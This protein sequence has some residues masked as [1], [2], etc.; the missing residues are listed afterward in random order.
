MTITA[1]PIDTLIHA[2]FGP[3]IITVEETAV[4]TI[5]VPAALEVSVIVNGIARETLYY[6]AI[7]TEISA[8][9]L[10]CRFKIDLS[11]VAQKWLHDSQMTFIN[12][13]NTSQLV[14]QSPYALSIA[15]SITSYLPNTEG[16]LVKNNAST[17]LSTPFK[18]SGFYLNETESNTII[19]PF[20]AT[21]PQKF[22]TNIPSVVFVTPTDKVF[23]YCFNRV[24]TALD[25]VVNFYNQFNALIGTGSF[26]FQPL[27]NGVSIVAFGPSSVQ[28]ANWETTN[29][30]VNVNDCL[31]YDVSIVGDTW[32]SEIKRF[33]IDFA[34]N[35]YRLHFLNKMG[36]YDFVF[37]NTDTKES[38]SVKSELFERLGVGIST[39]RQS[40]LGSAG[41]KSHDGIA[42]NLSD[43]DVIWLEELLLSPSVFWENDGQIVPIIVEDVTNVLKETAEQNQLKVSFYLSKKRYSQKL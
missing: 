18:T 20:T 6:D 40:R 13:Y 30:N 34:C 8:T 32:T 38:M 19:N 39:H 42:K 4:G 23:L 27:Q 1:Q 35:G 5:S 41:Q 14:S 22:L 29:G 7:E 31:Y 21:I 9:D 12:N 24:P 2:A 10:V 15:A 37:L 36:G 16:L 28:N 17:L 25:V 3:L 43:A 11:E 26:G 33:Q